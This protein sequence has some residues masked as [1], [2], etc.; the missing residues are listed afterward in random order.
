MQHVANS[1]ENNKSWAKFLIEDQNGNTDS[2]TKADVASELLTLRKEK[3][4]LEN[5]VKSLEIENINLSQK[6]QLT[7][8]TREPKRG[9]VDINPQVYQYNQALKHKNKFLQEESKGQQNSTLDPL[10]NSVVE[11]GVDPGLFGIKKVSNTSSVKMPPIDS[12]RG[13]ASVAIQSEDQHYHQESPQ[14][15]K[16]ES[17]LKA[18]NTKPIPTPIQ[19]KQ[20]HPYAM[21]LRKPNSNTP[22][23]HRVSQ[24]SQ[25]SNY[26]NHRR[27]VSRD[28]Q[29]SHNNL[30]FT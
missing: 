25:Q 16:Y 21:S 19:V 7:Y 10:T 3:K 5:R 9:L 17:I 13:K 15:S 30:S 18:V 1:N 27:G 11:N 12:T 23:R 8:S 28:S 4:M 14:P 6:L 2:P 20:T 24:L 29:S 22:L 26:S